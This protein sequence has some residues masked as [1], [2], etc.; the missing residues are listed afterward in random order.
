MLAEKYAE[1]VRGITPSVDVKLIDGVD[2]I[3]VVSD[4]RA[5]SVIAD[6]VAKGESG[7]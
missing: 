3:G 2:H 5:V 4:P 6:D 1:A 7:A